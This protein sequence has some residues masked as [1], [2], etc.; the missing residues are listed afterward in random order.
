MAVRTLSVSPNATR[1]PHYDCR[2]PNSIFPPLTQ[3]LSLKSLNTSWLGTSKLSPIRIPLPEHRPISAAALSSLPTAKPERVFSPTEEVPKWSLKAIKSFA[4]AELEARKLNTKGIGTEALLLGILLEATNLAA[5]FLWA[6]GITLFKAR[7]EAVKL[8]GAE[9]KKKAVKLY[10]KRNAVTDREPPPLTESA[11]RA[12]DWA[13][14]KKLKSGE[15]G[16]ITPA[17]LLLGVWSEKESDGYKI[18]SALGFNDEKAKQLETLISKPGI[19]D[20]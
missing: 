6:N 14:D 16:E 15:S 9:Q 19:G 5:N 20:D 8:Y 10:G 18:M 12:L 1:T 13:F 4:M 3:F 11:Q 17:R 2:R 7:E